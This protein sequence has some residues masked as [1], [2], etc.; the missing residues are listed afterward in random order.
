MPAKSHFARRRPTKSSRARRPKPTTVPSLTRMIKRVQLNQCETRRST[1]FLEGQ[2]TNHNTTEYVTNLLKTTPGDF[3]NAGMEENTANRQGAEVVAK[4]ILCKFHYLSS[5][6]RPNVCGNIY[7]FSYPSDL[8]IDD[9]VFW[10]GPQGAGAQ[11]PRL[12]DIPNL[13]NITIL[14]KISVQNRNNYAIGTAAGAGDARLNGTMREFYYKFPL[15]KKIKY[16]DKA[17]VPKIRDYGIAWVFYDANNT[18]TSDTV[19]YMSYSH[20]F[21]YKDP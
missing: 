6:D 20:T 5:V 17:E 1:D 14:R 2:V 10:R 13:N 4:G 15:G 19:G 11:M 3:Q 9:S 16:D 21:Y 18:L 12:V 8:T 7:L